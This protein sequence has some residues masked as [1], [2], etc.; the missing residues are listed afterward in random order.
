MGKRT[1]KCREKAVECERMATLVTDETIRSVYLDL[2]KQWLR[3]AK[4]AEE[5][6]RRFSHLTIEYSSP[7]PAP[8]PDNRV[9]PGRR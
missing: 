4:D 1:D 3:M 7:Y 6:E 9:I 2:A 8:N 5:L